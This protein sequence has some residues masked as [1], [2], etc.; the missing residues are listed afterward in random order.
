MSV[1]FPAGWT[2]SS[3]PDGWRATSTGARWTGDVPTKMHVEILLEKTSA[4]S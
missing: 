1:R 2:S 4:Q 3:L